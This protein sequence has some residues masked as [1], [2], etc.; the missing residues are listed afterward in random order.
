MNIGNLRSLKIKKNLETFI[1]AEA[2]WVTIHG[3]HILIDKEGDIEKGDIGQEKK[4]LINTRELATKFIN[5]NYNNSKYR[6]IK[7]K[8]KGANLK[9]QEVNPLEEYINY[10]YYLINKRERGGDQNLDPSFINSNRALSDSLSQIIG[11]NRSKQDLILFRGI[12]KEGK[13]D[14]KNKIKGDIVTL[15]SFQSTTPVEEVA[16]FY[17]KNK[18]G[19]LIKI[20]APKGT[21]LIGVVKGNG[22]HSTDPEFIIQKNLKYEIVESLKENKITLRIVK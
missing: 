16:N 10:G 9:F 4:S 11:E 18:S 2:H 7:V 20:L 13:Q 1:K 12:N 6:D 14:F 3:K 15:K 19:I 21:P 8:I 22:G 17:K 5:E